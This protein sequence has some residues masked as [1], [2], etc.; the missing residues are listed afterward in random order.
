MRTDTFDVLTVLLDAV[1]EALPVIFIV[2]VMG[3]L[4]RAMFITITP[5]NA[6]SA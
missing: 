6:F 1:P 4:P 5:S 2:M 3:W